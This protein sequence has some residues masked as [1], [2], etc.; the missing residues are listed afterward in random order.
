L[1][2]NLY[3]LK[4]NIINPV[5]TPGWD[6][7]LLTSEQT[8]FF[9]TS[10]WARVLS[11]AY[12]YK[13]LYFSVIEGGRLAGLIPVME[14]DSFLT[15][16]RGVSLPFT[17]ACPVAA[18]TRDIFRSLQDAVHEHG[19][20][21]GWKGIE[22][23]GGERYFGETPSS[24][25]YFTHTLTLDA[26]ESKVFAS[27]KSNTRRNIR[28]AG[29]EGVEVQ[30][31]NSREAVDIFYRMNCITRRGHHLPP[32]PRVF[33]SKIFEH[34]LAMRKGF[35]AVAFHQDRP[36]ASA[37][38]FH[39]R[40]EAIYKYGA[41][42][43]NFL[44]LR[45]NNLVMWE[46]IRWFCRN[47]AQTLDLGRTDPEDEGLLQFKRG[48]GVQERRK[49]YYTLSLKENAF[50]AERNGFSSPYWIFKA[51]PIPLLRLAGRVL[52]RHVG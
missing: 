38:Y 18:D 34:I 52:Y 49:A 47:G 10:A 3:R 25:E 50:S 9:H 11:E 17:D 23:R 33:F 28:R 40:S 46:A 45:V 30:L 42:D 16:K 6:D 39:F 26:D 13:P 44:R 19:K 12:G 24:A 21:A 36:V 27:F 31:L 51:L 41:S 32:Q 35:V 20:Q 2:R 14:I 1:I 29:A 48:W 5:E 37:I 22:F 4:I 8:T 7:L 43:K 15:G